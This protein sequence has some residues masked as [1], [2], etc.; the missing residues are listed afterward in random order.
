MTPG[1]YSGIDAVES[2]GVDELAVAAA[3]SRSPSATWTDVPEPGA[4][5]G[6]VSSVFPNAPGVQTPATAAASASSATPTTAASVVR[7]TPGW[8]AVASEASSARS[9]SFARSVGS[10]APRC[11]TARVSASPLST[12]YSR[13]SASIAGPTC[14]ASCRSASRLVHA[15]STGVTTTSTSDRRAGVDP[16]AERERGPRNGSMAR[17]IGPRAARG[18][19]TTRSSGRVATIRSP[20][21]R[22]S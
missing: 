3:D 1:G 21:I 14:R 15:A 22:V 10:D 19:R 4:S 11:R 20:S 6:P 12:P 13:R 9:W 7:S 8:S 5:G 18:K 17:G 2:P 16:T